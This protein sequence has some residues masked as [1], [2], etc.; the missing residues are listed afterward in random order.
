MD[1]VLV[2]SATFEKMAYCEKEFIKSIKELTYPNYDI[3]IVDNSK[4][5]DYSAHLKEFSGITV[6]HDNTQEE[7]SI[8]RLISSRNKIIDYAL[9]NSYDYILM[10]DSDVLLPKNAIE[11]LINT[12]KSLVSGIYYNYFN[13]DSKITLLPV[14]W[15][16]F[17]EEEFSEIKEKYPDFNQFKTRFEVPRHMTKQEIESNKTYEVAMPSAGAMLIKKDVFSKVKYGKYTE[18][19]SKTG[20]DVYFIEKAKELGFA[21][22]VNTKVKCSHLIA[23]KYK[24]DIEG[25]YIHQSFSDTLN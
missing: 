25:N 4:N 22:Y 3:L 9:K 16:Y 23:G 17:T 18:S 20:E 10:L 13:L 14:A 21:P 1:K 24:K 15:I 8:D 12:G 19:A 11:E 2:A 5:L 7:K 6:L